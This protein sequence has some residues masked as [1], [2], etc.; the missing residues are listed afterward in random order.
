MYICTEQTETEIGMMIL[1]Y[2][3]GIPQS[4][5]RKGMSKLTREEIEK[6]DEACR[7]AEAYTDN[8]ETIA[9]EDPSADTI[10]EIKKT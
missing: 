2:R 10:S 7:L 3:S 5:L 1:A 6:I 9:I 4:R 8:F